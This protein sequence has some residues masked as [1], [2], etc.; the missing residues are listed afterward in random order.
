MNTQR[1]DCQE[2]VEQNLGFSKDC[3]FEYVNHGGFQVQQPWNNMG[4]RIQAPAMAGGSE[5]QNPEAA[6]ASNTIMSSFQSP[7]SALYATEI[8]MGFPQYGSQQDCSAFCNSQFPS[9]HASGEIFPI[10]SVAGDEPTNESRNTSQSLVKSQICFNDQYQKSSEKSYKIP[11]SSSQGSLVPSPDQGNVT[12]NNAAATLGNH[13]SVP[14]Q[15][16]QDQR[17]YGDSYGPPVTKLSYF[18][19]EKQSSN[20]S[21]SGSS[22]SGGPVMASKTRIRWTQDLHDKFVESVKCLGGAEKATPK[23]I[24]RLMGTEGLTIFHVKSHLQKYRMAKYMP[25]SAEEKSEK[26]SGTSDVTQIDVKTGLHL[27]EALQL[28][29]DVQ[30]R[31]HEQLEIQRNLQLQIEEQ[32]RQLKMMID[33]QQKT[34]KG[35]LQ[36][37]D[38]DITSFDHDPSF[39]IDDLEA[40]IAESSGNAH[41]PSKI[42]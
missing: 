21:S 35:L 14:F 19:Q 6:K 2:H 20:Y 41:F 9:L 32:G 37:Q 30:R 27:T 39:S 29:L 16:N 40:S 22:V 13:F 38:L 24:L 10:E 1:I 12:R 34:K 25:D 5:Q 23:A 3:S 33:Q 26:R 4:I 36:K 18:Q 7:A 17:A 11:R 15:G 8:C 42:S 31:L 28:Q